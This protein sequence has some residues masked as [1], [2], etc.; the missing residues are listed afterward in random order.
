MSN[1][2]M[3]QRKRLPDHH[4]GATEPEYNSGIP[5]EL[6]AGACRPKSL[7]EIIARMVFSE[8]QSR[9]KSE[10]ES[11]DE[12]NDFDIPDELDNQLDFSPYELKDLQEEEPLQSSPQPPVE[13]NP[14]QEA[15]QADSGSPGEH[16]GEPTEA[17]G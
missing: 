5:V 15:A 17:P 13:T 16:D 7:Q 4:G 9:E 14:P 2:S 12:A 8:V 3:R 6:P 11:W 1:E 10:A